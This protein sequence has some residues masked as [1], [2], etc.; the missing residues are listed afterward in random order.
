MVNSARFDVVVIGMGPGGE[1]AASRLL[2]AGRRVAVVERELIGGECG[3]WACIPSKTL[4]RPVEAR[5]GARGAAGLGSPGLDWA[6]LRGYR[7]QMIRHLDDTR[8]VDEYRENGATV[9][10]G[11]ARLVGRDPWRVEVAGQRLTAEHVVIATGSAAVRPPIEGLDEVEVWTNREA[12][13]LTEI[14]ERAV[15]VG[16]GAVGVELA[17]FL[18]GM[19]T[20]VVLAQRGDRLLTREEPRVGELVAERL[21]RDGV[22]VRTGTQVRRAARAG[23]GTVVEFDDGTRE[24]TDVVILGAGRRPRTD[25]LGLADVGVEAGERGLAVDERCRVADGLWAAGDVTGVALF[26]HVAKYQGRLVA[27]GILGRERRADYTGVPRVVFA[28][29]EIAAVGLTAAQAAAAG[30]ETVAAEVDLPTS[31]ARPW[32][33]ETE[34][35]GTLGLLADRDRR[36]LVG[37]WA[38]APLSGEWIHTAALAIRAGLPVDSLD[39]GIAQFPTYSEGYALA[40]ERLEF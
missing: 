30:I 33:Y 19:G 29:P 28:E 37:A 10:R 31:L 6:G 14:P 20:R 39:D 40:A 32:T 13:T 18:A 34:P 35:R 21:R 7:D 25:G 23:G 1:V 38:V 8:Q 4:L 5:S 36:T 9:L 26:T 15:L 2:A 16:G 22:D 27:D 17:Y 11:A 24:E 12:T 3:Y